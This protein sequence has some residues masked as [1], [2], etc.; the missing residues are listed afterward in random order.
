MDSTGKMTLETT[1][2]SLVV[3]HIKW[4]EL[5]PCLN[6][7]RVFA[8]EFVLCFIEGQFSNVNEEFIEIFRLL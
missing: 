3:I 5:L 7:V 8:I 4:L 2:K 6:V 1:E